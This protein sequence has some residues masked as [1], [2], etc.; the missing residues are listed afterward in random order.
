[1]LR[2]LY[3]IS[4]YL[5]ILLGLAHILFTIPNY[6]WRWTLDAV[7]FMSAGFAIVFA[8]F[9]NLALLRGAGSDSL[10]R[11]LCLISN[12]LL[13]L[14]FGAAITLLNQPQV[15]FGMLLFAFESVAVLLLPKN[16]RQ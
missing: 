15:Y 9:L 11:L 8:G 7:W 6:G 12:V 14:L 2:T 13:A 1:M 4:T 10:V 5:V 16:T 3:R